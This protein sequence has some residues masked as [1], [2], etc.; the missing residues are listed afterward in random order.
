MRCIDDTM[1]ELE[2]SEYDTDGSLI[3]WLR[4]RANESGFPVMAERLSEYGV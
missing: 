1:D 3:T 4:E 2:S